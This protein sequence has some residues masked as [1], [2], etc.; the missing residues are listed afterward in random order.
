MKKNVFMTLFGLVLIIKSLMYGISFVQDMSVGTSEVIGVL[1]YLILGNLHLVLLA[2]PIYLAK[3]DKPGT[4]GKLLLFIMA[5]FALAATIT[6]Y[7]AVYTMDFLSIDDKVSGTAA[8]FVFSTIPVVL[9]MMIERL[10]K[11]YGGD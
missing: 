8:A 4:T 11:R 5:I 10:V 3:R 7:T 6:C 1:A 2:M 9:Y